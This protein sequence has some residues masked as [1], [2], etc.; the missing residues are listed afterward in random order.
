MAFLRGNKWLL[1]TDG[2][3]LIVVAVIGGLFYFQYQDLNSLKKQ[4][5]YSSELASQR[6]AILEETLAT[7]SRELSQKLRDQQNQSIAM[8]DNLSGLSGTLGTLEKLSKTDRELLQ[9]YSKVYFL[10]DNFV[11]L[12]LA[13]IAE[14]YLYDKLKPQQF[15]AAALPF[16]ERMLKQASLDLSIKIVSGYRSFGTQ[17]TLKNGYLVTY[18]SGA[19]Q[20]S[21]D[22]G[23][24]EHQLGTAVDITTDD[25]KP[26]LDVKFEETPT[27]VWLN[28][29]AFKYGFIL[30]YPKNN[31][32]YQYEPW[33]W[34]F[35][36][37]N[38]AKRLHQDGINFSDMDQRTIDSYLVNIFD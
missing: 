15:H 24:S 10:S 13:N 4:M 3:M 22:Q 31:K 28:N 33:H 23:Y 12:E 17:S 18:G 35:V 20:F 26:S 25:L 14:N 19:N 36:G 1:I 37:V 2:I 6:M 34:R 5:S 9:K 21:A 7:T 11:P 29:N 32:Y 38:L 8:Q 30:S 27:F 16:L